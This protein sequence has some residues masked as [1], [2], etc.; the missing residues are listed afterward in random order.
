MK[1]KI[2]SVSNKQEWNHI[3][4]KAAFYD[5]Y[6][7]NSYH[8]LDKSGSAFLFVLEENDDFIAIPLIKRVI[9]GTN[10]YD[11][12]S[13]WGYPGPISSKLPQEL[14]VKLVTSFGEKMREFMLDS[15]IVTVFSRLH[16]LIEQQYC[17]KGLGTVIKLNKTVAIDLSLPLDMQRQQYR[18]SN[19]SEINQLRKSG[20]TI[21]KAN[22]SNEID[23]FYDIYINT[24]QRVNADPFYFNCFDLEYFY[25]LL[26]LDDA[27]PN[28]L[29]AYKD[30]E[31]IAGGVFIATEK[32]MQ[33]HVAGTK[34]GH[35]KATPMKLIIDEARLLGNQMNL[36]YLHLGGGVN[37]TDTD[38]L[39]QFKA[40][41]SDYTFHY[42]IWKFIVDEKVYHHLVTR[43]AKQKQ[44]NNNFFPLYRC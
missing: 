35:M 39:F 29:L 11:C 17:F 34:N 16:P 12:T 2:V 42:Q 41:F 26:I 5:F 20:Y 31:I 32:F 27:R 22:T 23:A 43:K 4:T 10:Y 38:S 14:P 30:E 1:T 21:R 44:L 33:Y 3:V 19:K 36:K 15:K 40:G 25:K 9:E 8:S 28:L 24:M 13:V 7:C 18:K 37:G 6:H